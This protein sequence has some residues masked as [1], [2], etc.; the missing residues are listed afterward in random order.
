MAAEVAVWWP[1]V[2][3]ALVVLATAWFAKWRLGDTAKFLRRGLRDALQ[4]HLAR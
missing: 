3:A 2:V 4:D 1:W